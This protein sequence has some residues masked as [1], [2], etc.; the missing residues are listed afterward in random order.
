MDMVCYG[1]SIYIYMILWSFLMATDPSVAGEEE[2][3]EEFF[4]HKDGI[5][6]DIICFGCKNQMP[7]G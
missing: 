7:K 4:L 6:F 1:L 3:R 2:G 5:L